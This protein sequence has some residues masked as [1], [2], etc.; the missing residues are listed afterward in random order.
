MATVIHQ[1]V[2][3]IV[4]DNNLSAVTATAVMSNALVL[5]N[6]VGDVEITALTS[7]CK[8]ANN[9]TATTIQYNVT[10]VGTSTSQTIS[11]VTSSL[12]NAAIG[13]NIHLQPNALTTVPTLTNASGVSYVPA[14]GIHVCG[15]STINLL[16]VGTTTGTWQHTIYFVPMTQG[17]F[18][19]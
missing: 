7:I 15:G 11:G 12:A 5:F 2:S 18:V 10:N 13:T 19:Y 16:V 14:G 3:G 6:V 9:S 4:Q 1:N 8:T 17:A